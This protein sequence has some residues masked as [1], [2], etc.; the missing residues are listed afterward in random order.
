MKIWH[1]VT[2]FGWHKGNV[3]PHKIVLEIDQVYGI[4]RHRG[5]RSKSVTVF[6]GMVLRAHGVSDKDTVTLIK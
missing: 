5:F 3:V 2:N 4:A 1:C 6:G